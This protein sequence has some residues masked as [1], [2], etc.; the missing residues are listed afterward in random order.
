MN[1]GCLVNKKGGVGKTTN[2]IHL[3]ARLAQLKKR[4]LLIDFDPQCD[5]TLGTGINDDDYDYDV[6]DFLKGNSSLSPI[7]KSDNFFVLPGNKNLIAS[8]FKKDTLKKALKKYEAFFD[9]V[10]IDTPPAS[11]NLKELSNSEIALAASDF[12]MIAM[13]AKAYSVKNANDFLGSIKSKIIHYNKDLNFLG[14]FFSNV[15]VTKKNVAIWRE[16]MSDKA[17]DLL[18]DSFI[19]TDS[20]VEEAVDKG[21]TIFQYS[22]QCRASL[23]YVSFTREFL[24]KI[25]AHG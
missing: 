8:D 6:L 4:T 12:Y 16:F 15:L 21:M 24:K 25:K 14:F 11:I 5:L 9:F 17:G 3:G 10:L 2:T 19:R 1:V 13:E 22:P 18:F 20:K 23:D 7:Q